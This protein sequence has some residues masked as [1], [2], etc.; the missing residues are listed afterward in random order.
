MEVQIRRCWS[1]DKE[2]CNT[3][4]GPY[5][6]ENAKLSML[7]P[8]YLW[9]PMGVRDEISQTWC[10]VLRIY[11]SISLWMAKR[12]LRTFAL[13]GNCNVVCVR[14]VRDVWEPVPRDDVVRIR[15]MQERSNAN[16][17]THT[18]TKARNIWCTWRIQPDVYRVEHMHFSA[19]YIYK[20]RCIFAHNSTYT[21][22]LSMVKMNGQR[23]PGTPIRVFNCE[24]TRVYT[25]YCIL[26]VDMFYAYGHALMRTNACSVRSKYRWNCA[27]SPT[28]NFTDSYADT[29]INPAKG[30]GRWLSYL[31]SAWIL[32]V[33][34]PIFPYA[35]FE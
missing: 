13:H 17:N 30:A 1:A 32:S 7:A 16:T 22:T 11:S 12:I 3:F 21:H 33:H 2:Y 24:N 28:S 4:D 5:N 29:G 19:V 15:A 25:L 8:I 23:T 26:H 9:D 18:H 6:D 20:L 14:F 10:K 34:L 27:T 35:H 31:V